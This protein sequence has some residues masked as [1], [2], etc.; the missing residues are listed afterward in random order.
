MDDNI[1]ISMLQSFSEGDRRR[2]VKYFLEKYD[3]VAMNM[4][5]KYKPKLNNED[6]ED[7]VIASITITLRKF[8]QPGVGGMFGSYLK[9]VVTSQALLCMKYKPPKPYKEIDQRIERHPN[10]FLDEVDQLIS[11]LDDSRGFRKYF[12]FEINSHDSAFFMGRNTN[13]QIYG[14]EILRLSDCGGRAQAR[15]ISERLEMSVD[16]IYE[17]AEKLKFVS[18]KIKNMYDSNGMLRGVER[19]I[20]DLRLRERSYN[21]IANESLVKRVIPDGVDGIKKR[22]LKIS[23]RKY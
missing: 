2:A 10:A 11:H 23:N 19:L 22:V 16:D 13:A 4:A 14:K 6:C 8:E 1:Y 20:V 18:K 17:A 5:N 9:D 15:F 21:E 3:S 12:R 7:V